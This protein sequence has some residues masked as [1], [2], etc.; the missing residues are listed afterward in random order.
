MHPAKV[1]QHSNGH[2]PSQLAGFSSELACC[3][4]HSPSNRTLV[5]SNSCRKSLS[6]GT[7]QRLPLAH[8]SHTF[9]QNCQRLMQNEPG[10]EG[11]WVIA[12][13]R[14]QDTH[15]CLDALVELVH[16]NTWASAIDSS[17]RGP[18]ITRACLLPVYTRHK[19]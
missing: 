12:A 17:D 16:V 10:G 11:N 6:Y 8:E 7:K 9:H 5:Q 15:L 2:R 13:K 1:A 19:M 4:A 18:T 14:V 3:P